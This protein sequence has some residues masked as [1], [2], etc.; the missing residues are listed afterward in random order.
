M[1]LMWQQGRQGRLYIL[2]CV[3]CECSELLIV[4]LVI[5]LQLSRLIVLTFCQRAECESKSSSMFMRTLLSIY[6]YL[7]PCLSFCVQLHP[8]DHVTSYPQIH[9]I[10]VCLVQWHKFF[11]LIIHI[12]L[13]A[14][15]VIGL[16][17]GNHIVGHCEFFPISCTWFRNKHVTF[18]WVF[19]LY[20]NIGE[21]WLE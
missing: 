21:M 11:Y 12:T 6:V 9:G 2:T 10:L 16:S 4:I 20:W 1:Q 5:L 13:L 3:K 14:I 15:P 19:L 7:C 17:Q 8:F 18:F